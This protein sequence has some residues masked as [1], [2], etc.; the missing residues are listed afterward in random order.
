[1]NN[2]ELAVKAKGGDRDALTAL[3]LNNQRLLYKLVDKYQGIAQE[4]LLE[5]EDL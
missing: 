5:L 2:E 4:R 3:Y 1:M